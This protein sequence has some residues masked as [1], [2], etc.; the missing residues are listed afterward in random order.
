[1]AVETPTRSLEARRA[2][3]GLRHTARV[4]RRE[5]TAYLFLSPVFLL[6]A[7]FTFFSV[8][9][10]FYL[11]FHQWNILEPHKPFVGLAFKIEERKFGQLTYVGVYQGRSA[12]GA[13][14][15]NRTPRG[16]GA[17]NLAGHPRAR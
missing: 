7:I 10:A 3:R 2:P 12:R 11:S 17:G 1:M 5:W 6:F 13:A 16:A 15:T 8:G 9:Y 14:R 4:A